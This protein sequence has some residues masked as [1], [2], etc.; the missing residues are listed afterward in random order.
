MKKG[1]AGTGIEYM[2]GDLVGLTKILGWKD[3]S[4][5]RQINNGT[6]I[7]RLPIKKY[8]QFIE[9]G[10]FESGYVR[11]MNGGY[12]PYQL[13]KC[14][15]TVE[16]Y[17]DYKWNN[18]Y[19]EQTFTGKYNKYVGKK[20]ITIDTKEER[21]EHLITYCLKNY[22]INQ[23]NQVEE[24]KFISKWKHE[25]EMKN[26]SMDKVRELQYE[27]MKYEKTVRELHEEID[28]LSDKYTDM[29]N[30]FE[31]TAMELSDLHCS[32]K[33]SKIKELENELKTYV[34]NTNEVLRNL[35]VTVNGERYKII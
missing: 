10:S 18:D 15:P 34:N 7:Y 35:S 16:Y 21:L 11:R 13:N 3:V 17:R 20:R 31:S 24:G 19:S 27:I 8:G 2:Y 28:E 25:H 12:T 1:I 29:C 9:V 33:D 23:A 30:K 5:R 26:G 32:G 22:Y 14:E 6:T 4:T